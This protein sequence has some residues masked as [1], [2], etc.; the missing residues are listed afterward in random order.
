MSPYSWTKKQR[1]TPPI[2]ESVGNNRQNIDSADWWILSG[3]TSDTRKEPE[4]IHQPPLGLLCFLLVKW[5]HDYPLST[6]GALSQLALSFFIPSFNLFFFLLPVGSV[7]TC[8]RLFLHFKKKSELFN[9]IIKWRAP[10]CLEHIYGISSAYPLG[11][12]VANHRAPGTGYRSVAEVL[13]TTI[14]CRSGVLAEN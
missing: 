2:T 1:G 7:V 12:Y 4:I 5:H 14:S 13:L 6:C 10:P 9:C 8:L 11:L 3:W